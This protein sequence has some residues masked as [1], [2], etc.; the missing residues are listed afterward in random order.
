MFRRCKPTPTHPILHSLTSD[1]SPRFDQRVGSEG[2]NIPFLGAA[3]VSVAI[4]VYILECQLVVHLLLVWWSAGCPRD[5]QLVVHVPVR[6]TKIG[7]FWQSLEWTVEMWFWWKL[8]L[9]CCRFDC[10]L[11]V[12][13]LSGR[14]KKTWCVS[15][16]SAWI[17]DVSCFVLLSV[18]QVRKPRS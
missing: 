13:R 11:G 9:C 4:Y 10:I 7:G 17:S 6:T 14:K 1:A 15:E 12:E 8:R 3:D 2:T 18:G 16:G 5:G